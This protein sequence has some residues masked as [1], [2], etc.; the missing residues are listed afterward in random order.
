MR[1]KNNNSGKSNLPILYLPLGM[2]IGLSI[3]MAIGAATDNIPLYMS[4]GLSIG[5]GLGAALDARR[6]KAEQNTPPEDGQ[7]DG[8]KQ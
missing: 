5:V 8:Q 6:Q 3:G 4:I 2:S 7:D 1:K